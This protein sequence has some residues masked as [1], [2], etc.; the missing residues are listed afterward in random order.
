MPPGYPDPMPI[1]VTDYDPAWPGL[2]ASA[3]A[4]LRAALPG[5]FLAIEHM[6]STSVPG[7]AAKPV[8][9]LMAAAEEVDLVAR[10]ESV[11]RE[12]GYDR[13]DTGMPGRLFYQR[14]RDGR[15]TRHLHV[16]PVNDFTTRNEL[17]LRDY[18]RAHPGAAARYAELKRQLADVVRSGDEYTRA[19]TD[20]I[21]EL[22]DAAR[23][24]RGLPSVPVWEEYGQWARE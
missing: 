13:F 4:E 18:L 6:G 7:L 16:V 24:E 10:H 3:R 8:I 12:L 11:L 19:K 17:L 1:D 20:L 2:A 5:V 21:Q 14:D 15:R 9:D 22:T 23:A